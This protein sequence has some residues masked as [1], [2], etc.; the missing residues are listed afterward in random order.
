MSLTLLFVCSFSGL[1]LNA[2]SSSKLRLSS[3]WIFR[4]WFLL[5][6]LPTLLFGWLKSR[7]YLSSVDVTTSRRL[8]NLPSS[9]SNILLD[10]C[11]FPSLLIPFNF[12]LWLTDFGF[13]EL[14]EIS[15]F[16]VATDGFYSSSFWMDCSGV[17][18]A[19]N[20]GGFTLSVMITWL[21]SSSSCM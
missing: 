2:S 7:L 3:V 10:V 17:I 20:L 8:L 6:P 14:F 12:F 19:E 11:I 4:I 16:F 5:F 21:S 9:S 15:F 1:I 13:S 18:S